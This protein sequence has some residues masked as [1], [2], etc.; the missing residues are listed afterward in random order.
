MT[1][2]RRR[3]R[4]GLHKK[5]IFAVLAVFCIV[6]GLIGLIIPIIPGLIF[7]FV[8]AMLLSSVSTRFD[9]WVN[10]QPGMQTAKK[11]WGSFSQ[12]DWTDR[13]RLSAWMALDAT[14]QTASG[15]RRAI[16]DRRLRN[17]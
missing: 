2:R 6:L 10:N 15:V 13:A 7:L 14:L 11:R 16:A 8:A 12:L 4:D 3:R 9:A 17:R 5:V 1:V